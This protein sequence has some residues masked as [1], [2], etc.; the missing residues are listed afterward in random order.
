MRRS[1]LTSSALAQYRG[2]SDVFADYKHEARDRRHMAGFQF[3]AEQKEKAVEAVVDAAIG[4]GVAYG[5]GYYQGRSNGMPEFFHL[6][7]DL[8]AALALWSVG[9]FGEGY[10]GERNAQYVNAAGH[11]AFAFWAGNLGS[12]MGCEARATANQPPCGS[13]TPTDGTIENRYGPFTSTPALT[14]PAKTGAGVGGWNYRAA[15]VR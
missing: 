10:L 4:G 14:T 9:I 6:G 11:G 15:H 3:G 13:P 12:K 1:K 5:L 7:Y 8:W 2:S